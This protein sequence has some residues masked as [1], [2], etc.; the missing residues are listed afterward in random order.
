MRR[1]LFALGPAALHDLRIEVKKL[2]YAV[3]FLAPTAADPLAAGAHMR[4]GAG[5]GCAGRAA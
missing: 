4:A 3:D 2:R 1:Q 5:A